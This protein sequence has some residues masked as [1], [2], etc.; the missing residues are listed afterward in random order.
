MPSGGTSRRNTRRSQKRRDTGTPDPTAT[1]TRL[2]ELWTPRGPVVMGIVNCTPDSFSDG[3]RFLD[4]RRRR[5][6]GVSAISRPGLASSTSV[7]SRPGPAPTR[8][9]P[10]RSRRRVVPVIRELRTTPP[11][12]RHLRRHHQ[13]RGRRER[14]FDAGADIVNDVSAG[15]EAGML[16]LVAGSRRRHRAHAP[17]RHT[18]DHAAGHPLRRC[19]GRGPRLSPRPGEPPPSTP[20]SRSATGVARPRHRFRQGRRRQSRPPRRAARSRRRWV[21]RW[22]SDR[23]ASPLSA[24]SPA[25]RS[26]TVS[27]ARWPR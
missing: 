7:E 13:G 27:A 24:V 16:E 10:T 8:W 20:A 9:T 1:A 5:R 25:H 15:A 22:S 11:I 26:R 12:R 23:R 14:P 4:C 17:P 6:R 19:R 18:R 2:D 3:G 21:I